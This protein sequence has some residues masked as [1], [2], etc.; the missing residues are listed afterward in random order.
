[1]SITADEIKSLNSLLGKE[2]ENQT[3]VLS[4]I[5]KDTDSLNHLRLIHGA[6]NLIVLVA[7]DKK[8]EDRDEFTFSELGNR[9]FHDCSSAY[10]LILKGYYHV[11]T[12]SLRDLLEC[13]FLL[14]LFTVEPSKITEWRMVRNKKGDPP[15]KPAAL[16]RKFNET[17]AED[18]TNASRIDAM[19][20]FFCKIG[21]HPTYIGSLVLLRQEG[22]PVWGSY[23][24]KEKTQILLLLLAQCSTL[25]MCHLLQAFGSEKVGPRI[26]TVWQN[27]YDNNWS[28]WISKYGGFLDQAS[29][30]KI[31][32]FPVE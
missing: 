16:R 30:N 24:Q 31:L 23:F 6:I 10:S 3:T 1:M 29:L 2:I 25:A 12:M 4:F 19:Y 17:F 21:T 14:H 8:P 7:R 18:K 13:T 22:K 32:D 20:S 5:E 9:I 15:F 27:F 26:N 11:A 28:P